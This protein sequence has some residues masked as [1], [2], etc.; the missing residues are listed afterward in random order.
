MRPQTKG[1][2]ADT[3]LRISVKRNSMKQEGKKFMECKKLKN[4]TPMKVLTLTAQPKIQ[5]YISKLNRNFR[6]EQKHKLKQQR[7]TDMKNS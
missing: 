5:I 3:N 4:Q 1:R 7:S 2:S 6:F